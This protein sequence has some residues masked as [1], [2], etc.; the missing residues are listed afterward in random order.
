MDPSPNPFCAHSVESLSIIRI[1]NEFFPVQGPAQQMAANLARRLLHRFDP[2]AV[3]KIVERV[4]K[5][6]ERAAEG[7]NPGVIAAVLD[8]RYLETDAGLFDLETG[9]ATDT[10]VFEPSESIAVY[11]PCPVNPASKKVE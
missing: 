4:K 9:R 2:L 7:E 6:I 11:V 10:L 8:G 3:R 5:D 1:L